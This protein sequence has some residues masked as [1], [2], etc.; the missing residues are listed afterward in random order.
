MEGGRRCAAKPGNA[1]LE[2]R[3]P[4]RLAGS[5]CQ[6]LVVQTP[7]GTRGGYRWR[8]AGAIQPL[9][10]LQRGDGPCTL[11]LVETVLTVYCA[12]LPYAP[13]EAPA[14]QDRSSSH[15]PYTKTF[16]PIALLHVNRY[17]KP[18]RATLNFH[19]TALEL[20]EGHVSEPEASF[21]VW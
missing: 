8:V 19:V 2:H 14:C 11:R 6:A 12:T 7:L 16:S 9:M 5:H 15:I 18:R 21:E 4:D 1:A 3:Q 10:V 13:T 20:E 17:N